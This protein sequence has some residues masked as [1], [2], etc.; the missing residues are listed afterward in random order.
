MIAGTVLDQSDPLE[1]AGTACHG[2][3]LSEGDLSLCSLVKQKTSCSLLPP[4][5]SPYKKVDFVAFAKLGSRNSPCRGT[6]SNKPSFANGIMSGNAVEQHVPALMQFKRYK[7]DQNVSVSRT[8]RYLL[9][10]QGFEGLLRRHCATGDQTFHGAPDK[11]YVEHP[12]SVRKQ[13]IPSVQVHPRTMQHS[14][15]T[16]VDLGRQ[17]VLTSEDRNI[18]SVSLSAQR[19]QNPF[20]LPR[21]MNSR[22]LVGVD[23]EQDSS[24]R[25]NNSL[26]EKFRPTVILHSK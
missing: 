1:T 14:Q 18:T 7:S 19:L 20:D 25:C 11:S 3:Q 12:A 15:S 21:C 9:K 26:V 10:R 17:C 8:A 22:P 24:A 16:A 2:P 5:D 6:P 4:I 13:E 23:A